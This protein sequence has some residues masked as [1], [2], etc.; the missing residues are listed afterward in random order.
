MEPQYLIQQLVMQLH[1]EEQMEQME[2]VYL[3]QVKKLIID[4]IIQVQIQM[5]NLALDTLLEAPQYQP[6]QKVL[7]YELGLL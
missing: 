4:I 6:H 3:L 2:L 5:N 7:I 1:I